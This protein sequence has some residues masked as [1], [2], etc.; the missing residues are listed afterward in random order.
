MHH[1][2]SYLLARPVDFLNLDSNTSG[3]DWMAVEYL[4]KLQNQELP[5]V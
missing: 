4:T 2:C 3:H 5:P 1:Y